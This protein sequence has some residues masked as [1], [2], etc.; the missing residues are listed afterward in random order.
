MKAVN[1]ENDARAREVRTQL[2]ERGILGLNFMSSPGSGKTSLLE[3]T[4]KR[5]TGE[6]RFAVIEGDVF[7][8]MDAERIAR[9]G[10]EVIQLNTEG[11]CHLTAHMIL[12]V[13]PRLNLDGIDI[14]AIENIG[15]LI[16]P[17][18]YDLGEHRRVAC[19]STA[20]GEDKVD[21]YPK[22]FSISDINL[23][24]KADL[25]PHVNFDLDRVAAKLA[26]LNT[27]APVITTSVNTGE[28]LDAWS[29]WLRQ[30]CREA[31]AR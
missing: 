26:A 10:V 27:K 20:E 14:L 25:A 6:L 30:G 8:A 5:L 24:T 28:G 9:H 21:K 2:T 19:L 18:S 29:D 17:T 12:E 16:C 4:I 7:T 3:E 11:S 31:A 22:L 15:N 1:A 23:L 13:L